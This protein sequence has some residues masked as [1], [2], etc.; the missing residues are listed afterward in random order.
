MKYFKIEIGKAWWLTPL[1]FSIGLAAGFM[2]RKPEPAK[3]EYW[4]ERAMRPKM[5]PK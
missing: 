3:I 2:G 4:I 5:V 1:L